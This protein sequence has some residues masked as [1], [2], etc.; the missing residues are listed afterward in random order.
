M[1]LWNYTIMLIYT[2]INDVKLKIHRYKGL[3]KWYSM[4]KSVEYKNNWNNFTQ[5]KNE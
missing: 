5:I 3:E 4:V 1:I 2:I